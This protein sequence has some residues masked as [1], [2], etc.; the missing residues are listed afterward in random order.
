MDTD[1]ELMLQRRLAGIIEGRTLILITHRLSMLRIVDR[2]IVMENGRI[3]LDGPR[4]EVLARLRGRG[5]ARQGAAPSAPGAA[6]AVGQTQ[7]AGR[8]APVG[9]AV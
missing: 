9:G 3:K 6:R 1:S 5:S 4:D 8:R 7:A 2:L